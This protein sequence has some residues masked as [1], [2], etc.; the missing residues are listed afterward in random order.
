MAETLFI[1]AHVPD[2]GTADMWRGVDASP[3]VVFCLDGAL[4]GELLPDGWTTCTPD[5][6]MDPEDV[7][8]AFL[9]FLETWP[10]RASASRK[11]LDELLMVD[12]RYSVWWT[13]VAAHR[14]P[15]HGSFRYFRLAVLLNRAIE[16]YAP[17]TIRLLT[18]DPAVAM[19]VQ[20]RADA[21][22]ISVERAARCPPALTVRTD[23]GARWLLGSVIRA[24]TYWLAN[25]LPALHCRWAVRATTWKASSRPTVVFATRFEGYLALKN[26]QLSLVNWREISEALRAADSSIDQVFLPRALD[27]I[28]DTGGQRESPRRGLDAARNARAPMLVHEGFVPFRGQAGALLRQITVSCRFFRVEQSRRFKESF[29]FAGTDMAPVLVPQLRDAVAHIVDWSFKIGQLRGALRA[30][31]DVRVVIACEEMYRWSMPVLAAA[32]TLDI[33]TVG[34]QHGNMMPAHLTYRVPAGQMRCA[35]VPD[36]FAVY[37]AYA[38]EIVSGLGAYPASRVWITGAARLDALVNRR[39][40]KNEARSRLGLPAD[41]RVVVL[42][43]QTFSWF[44]VAIRAVMACVRGNPDVVLCVKK[45]PSSVAMSIDDLQALAAQVGADNV[46]VLDGDLDLLLFSCDVWISASSTTILEST[47]IGTPSVCVNFSGEP[48]RY[49]YVE[50]GASFPARSVAELKQSLSRALAADHDPESYSRRLAFLDRHAGPTR[51]GRASGT[52]AEH[53]IDLCHHPTRSAASACADAQVTE[54]HV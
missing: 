18:S 33:P 22:G 1:V 45:H 46:R 37:G 27:R 30:A 6:L 5:D 8:Q 13:S 43:T 23:S 42:A 24:A 4:S 7:R 36:Y 48:D 49:P 52:F 3:C 26:G 17:T 25:V 11:S 28:V 35:P 50:D 34:V 2:W 32:A 20:S 51:D 14:Q 31:G 29:R 16:R 44:A 12:G 9:D 54:V 15:D 21:A 38:K 39:M 41:K 40:P 47:L 19:L 53:V 10:Q